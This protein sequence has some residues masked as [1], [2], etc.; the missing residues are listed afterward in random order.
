LTT[1]EGKVFTIDDLIREAQE[2]GGEEAKFDENDVKII[3]H[4][5]G[6]VKKVAGGYQLR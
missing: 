2:I 6:F 5:A 4:K 3:L 1:E